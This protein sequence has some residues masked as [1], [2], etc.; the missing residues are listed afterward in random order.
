MPDLPTSCVRSDA[1]WSGAASLASVS[2]LHGVA[3]TPEEVVKVSHMSGEISNQEGTVLVMGRALGYEAVAM[4]G[5]YENLPEVSLPMLVA[6]READ[7][8]R[9]A[10]LHAVDDAQVTVGDALTGEVSV[11]ARARFAAVWT[12][13]VVQLTP[14]EEERRGLAAR[15]VELRDPVR[16]ALL[17]VGWAPPYGRRI[18]MLAGWG[19][20]VAVAAL[21][22][23]DGGLR[24]GR[25]WL[26]AAACAGSLWSW[27]ASDTCGT[28]SYARRLA[29]A[30]PVPQAGAALYALL[31]ASSF[32][33]V[34]PLVTSL[35]L[36]AAVGAHT[37]LL[38]E[39]AKAKVACWAC[40]LVA[41]AATLAAVLTIAGGGSVGA[42]LL[43]AA[44]TGG[45]GTLLLP[46]ARA[47]EE[48]IWRATAEKL[49]ADA[50][51]EPRPEGGV[52]LIAFTRKGCTSCAFFHAAVK[53]ALA[54][55]FGDAVVI[56]ERDLGSA[57]TVAPVILV[58][59]GRPT[60]FVGLPGGDACERVL[61]VVKEAVEGGGESSGPIVVHAG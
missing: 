49:A 61:T 35:A 58:L 17:A 11:W 18:A 37:A 52:R 22:P 40:V 33:P 12:G 29:G 59:G 36:G 46:R 26:L 14:V 38:A 53:P 51:A 57:R 9:F 1:P 16:Q 45:L 15:L 54:A 34:P 41:G 20:V 47:K 19:V 44:V 56:D 25:T 3:L 39:L 43:G 2:A 8:D 24:V 27:L 48:R 6:L 5:E 7:R 60:L 4:E 13:S 10:V 30:L 55:T 42:L 50:S 28:C 32:A 31:L 23:A 21:A